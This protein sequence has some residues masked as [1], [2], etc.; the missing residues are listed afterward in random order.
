[1]WSEINKAR[2]PCLDLWFRWSFASSFFKLQRILNSDKTARQIASNYT[3][4]QT[5]LI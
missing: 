2:P 5:A 4:Y 3:P 1:M